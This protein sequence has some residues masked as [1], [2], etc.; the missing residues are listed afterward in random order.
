VPDVRRVPRVWREGDVVLLAEASPRSL[1][2]SEYQALFGRVSG[3]PGPLDLEAE[4]RLVQIAWGAAPDCSLVHDASEGG[5]A[6]CLA[7]AAI[8]SGVGAELE[9]AD[10][11]VELFGETGGRVVLACDPED[12]PDVRSLAEEL[13]V[14]LW[15][16]G[17]VGGGT[18]L[19]V[20]LERL[21]YAWQ[22]TEN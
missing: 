5:V 22:G 4:A 13:G 19:G 9:L 15:E 12:V 21:R 3:Q 17:A 14:P 20:E 2:G 7:E 1:A 16:V 8:I 6:V 11:A 18:L 10:H